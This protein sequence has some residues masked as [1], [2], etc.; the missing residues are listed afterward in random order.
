MKNKNY[1]PPIIA[2]YLLR[3]IAKYED[4]IS[5]IG[6][7]EEEFVHHAQNT[8][9]FKARFWYWFNTM[10]SI[11]KFA[12]HAVRR[13]FTMLVNYMKIAVR[14]LIRHKGISFINLSGLAIGMACCILILLY[15]Q[16]EMSYEKFHENSDRIYRVGVEFNDSPIP[17]T[18]PSYGPAIESDYPEVEKAVRLYP[19]STMAPRVPVH[20][21][22]KR[23]YEENVYFA[24]AAVFEV[25]SFNMISGDP[26]NAL[27][28]AYT[29][30]IT[31]T[32]AD[33]YFG[34]EEP[35]GKVLKLNSRD[36][37]V[38]GVMEDVPANSHLK[39][40]LLCSFTTLYDQRGNEQMKSWRTALDYYTYILLADEADHN[41]LEKKFPDLIEKNMGADLNAMGA[42]VVLFLQ[43]LESI[44][45]HSEME[46]EMSANSDIAYI[47]IFSAIAVF[48]LL[49]A[50]INFMNLA[51]A[52]AS[53]RAK[54]VGLRKVMGAY[55]QSLVR[56]FLGESII[57]SILSLVIA[58]L[59]V[60]ITLPI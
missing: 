48:V 36:Y 50:C 3:S 43:P 54:E 12:K 41:E 56:Q 13:G 38:T 40:D 15:I 58:L 53:I 27:Q 26:A 28:R 1:R 18:G 10:N 25:F 16:Y 24:D 45:L 51:T 2:E 57:F 49:I 14:N 21:G 30:V 20:Y 29:I 11:P 23:F 37:T 60:K 4:E 31:E 19:M 34:S 47:Y 5:L 59:L 7:F 39:F 8:G 35:I 9:L 46:Y 6:D 33:R 52:R 32:T 55:R 17:V 42:T 22:S 44:H